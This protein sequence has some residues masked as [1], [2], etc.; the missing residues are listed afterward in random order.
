MTTSAATFELK[1][2]VMCDWYMVCSGE[3]WQ[4]K[5]LQELNV[6]FFLLVTVGQVLTSTR[7]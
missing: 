6:E 3:M 1:D 4:I 5:M 7:G 2:E